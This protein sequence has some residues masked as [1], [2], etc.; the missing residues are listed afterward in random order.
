MKIESLF[1][2]L[3]K[4]TRR[5]SIATQ[6][7]CDEVKLKTD[8]TRK[9]FLAQLKETDKYEIQSG[10]VAFISRKKDKLKKFIQLANRSSKGI[11]SKSFRASL[12]AIFSVQKR[13][14]FPPPPPTHAKCS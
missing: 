9:L 2:P 11:K 14:S 13:D 7:C 12:C 4:E 3:Q 5:D 6:Q 10:L 8:G 1:A